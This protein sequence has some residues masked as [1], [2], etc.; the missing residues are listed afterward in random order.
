MLKS[1]FTV[2]CI[3][4]LLSILSF[5]FIKKKEKGASRVGCFKAQLTEQPTGWQLVRARRGAG[6]QEKKKPEVRRTNE[7]NWLA[8]ALNRSAIHSPLRRILRNCLAWPSA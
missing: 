8:A 3:V 7:E 1:I 6:R 5:H 2:K 4:T